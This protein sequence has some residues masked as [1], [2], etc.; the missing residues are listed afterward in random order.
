VSAPSFWWHTLGP[1][2]RRAPLAGDRTADV[3]IAGGGYTGLWTAY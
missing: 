3:V 1:V 2:P